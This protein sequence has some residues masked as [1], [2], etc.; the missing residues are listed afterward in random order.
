[1]YFIH[2][3]QKVS[4]LRT[5]FYIK[6]TQQIQFAGSGGS[7]CDSGVGSGKSSKSILSEYFSS[8]LPNRSAS[9]SKSL[10]IAFSLPFYRLLSF[11]F[12]LFGCGSKLSSSFVCNSPIRFSDC[13]YKL[14]LFA[15]KFSSSFSKLLYR[16]FALLK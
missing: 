12:F 8:K 16:F 6:K 5:C 13:L 3:Q 2:F 4:Y 15:L 11:C 14:A 1:M 10:S 9:L 7:V